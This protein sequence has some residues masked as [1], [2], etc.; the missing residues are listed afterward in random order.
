MCI[1]SD[2]LCDYTN[3][4]Y[5][6]GRLDNEDPVMEQIK[7]EP[8]FVRF[9]DIPH[10]LG[11]GRLGDQFMIFDNLDG[12]DVS[13]S[14]YE[15]QP[16]KT[17]VLL[18]FHVISGGMHVLVNMH[19]VELEAN[20]VLTLMPGCV[21]QVSANSSDVQVFCIA[22]SEDF[23]RSVY[24]SLGLKVALT[25]RYNRY[26]KRG[27][28]QEALQ[29]S[30]ALYRQIKAELSRP[31]YPMQKHVIQRYCEIMALKDSE[32]Y[33][34]ETQDVLQSLSRKDEIFRQFLQL[35]E[36]DFK[37]ERSIQYY[38]S[39]LCLSPKY[40]SAVVREVSGKHGSQWIDDYVVFEAKAL[41]KQG[42]L[43][44]K[45]VSDWLNFPSQ[46]MFGRFFKKI[47]GVSPKKYK[48]M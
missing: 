40:L 33:M 46:S 39:Q 43:S 15:Q 34:E 28:N 32:F 8:V 10:K 23:F 7:V 47:T 16:V 5:F 6:C 11:Q 45:Q 13:D 25:Q 22:A 4:C 12:D 1:W 37:R 18:S 14:S 20:D 31:S 36:R 42:T 2:L 27:G 17:D 19:D 48:T 24:E 30:L 3:K 21:F 41:L 35:L 9:A 29:N 26:T 44:V 38:A